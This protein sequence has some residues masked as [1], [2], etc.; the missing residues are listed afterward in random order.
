[1]GGGEGGHCRVISVTAFATK[2]NKKKEEV[3][4]GNDPYTQRNIIIMRYI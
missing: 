2:K 3:E 4:V 1:M